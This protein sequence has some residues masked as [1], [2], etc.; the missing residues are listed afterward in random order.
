[1]HVSDVDDRISCQFSVLSHEFDERLEAGSEGILAKFSEFVA[2]IEDRSNCSFPS[3]PKL[4][5]RSPLFGQS[6]PLRRSVFIDDYPRQFQSTAGGPVPLGSGFAH[7]T[8][9]GESVARVLG[10]GAE[11]AQVQ[12]SS[13]GDPEVAQPLSALRRPSVSFAALQ[14][15][16][17]LFRSLRKRT[18]E[19]LL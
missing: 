16:T 4:P 12:G 18:I 9:S 19:T 14:G 2:R 15:L 3:E 10:V 6:Q 1:M 8:T 11:P 17:L 5:G 7:H 13:V